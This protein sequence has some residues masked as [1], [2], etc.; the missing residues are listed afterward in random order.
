MTARLLL[1]DDDDDYRLL[2]TL[3]LA[4]H[5]V[6]SVGGYA[7]TSAAAVPLARRLQPELVLVDLALPGTDGRLALPRMEEAAPASTIIA[8]SAFGDDNVGPLPGG[9]RVV[10]HLSKSV[11]PARL[12]EEIMAL[13]GL[14]G[15]APVIDC[16]RTSLA[17]DT[18]SVRAARRFVDETLQQWRFVDPL[19][20][21]SLLVSELVT[22]AVLHAG[23]E[24]EVAIQLHSGRVRVD[25]ADGSAAGMHRRGPS[26]AGVSG[27]GIALVEALSDAWGLTA[28]PEGKSV[29][30]EVAN[31]ESVG[32]G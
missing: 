17:P 19:G 8:T 12:G 21:V 11:P 14:A 9:G 26:D 27:R 25:V 20:T 30:F 28:R 1:V 29:W 6:L 15:G 31:R 22:N 3:A 32:H 7:P 18:A 4:G 10:G 5:P 13:A 2:V 16:A 24:V 23:S